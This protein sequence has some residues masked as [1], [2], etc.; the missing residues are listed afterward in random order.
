MMA[1]LLRSHTTGNSLEN[2]DRRA[3]WRP[4]IIKIAGEPGYGVSFDQEAGSALGC[5]TV[6]DAIGAHT[7]ATQ[8]AAKREENRQAR[9]LA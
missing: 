4:W 9:D 3:V 5:R 1:A 2:E 6:R 7:H 8:H